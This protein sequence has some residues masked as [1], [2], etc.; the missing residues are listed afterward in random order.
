MIRTI[1]NFAHLGIAVLAN[2]VHAFP[3]RK[4]TVI[5]VTGTDGKTTTTN[6]IYHILNSS[7]KKAAMIS[8]IGAAVGGKMHDIGFHVTTPSSFAVQK[9]IKKAVAVGTEYLVL[10]VTSHG[11]DQNRAYGIE[12]AIS[13]VTN[14]THEH[15]DYHKTYEKYL[16][17]K[18]K[19][20]LASKIAVLNRDDESYKMLSS[21]LRVPHSTY[22]GQESSKFGDRKIITYGIRGEAD[23]TAKRFPFKTK[24]LGEFNKY[25][26]LAAIAVCR[27]L[28]L[29]DEQITKALATFEAPV[30]RQ[31][32]VY[33]KDFTVMVDFAHT[34][35]S[36]RMLLPDLKKVTRGRLI[37]VFGAAA[38]R[39]TSKRPIM[40]EESAKYSDI[41]VL[42]AEDP[43]DEPVEKINEM[44]KAGIKNPKFEIRSSKQIQNSK[45]LSNTKYIIEISDRKKAIE[46][47]ISIAQKGDY[48]VV[49][50][51]SHEKSMNY[52]KGEEAW[53]EFEV[54]NNALKIR[55]SNHETRNNK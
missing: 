36:F 31:E 48:I 35:N 14:V 40:G 29:S 44:I 55:N 15:L 1:K 46:Y 41:I 23:V 9:Y 47:A 4:L 19:L 8:T 42:T 43:R 49:T 20:L 26:C 32:I 38:Q 37:H 11:L 33:D 28:G 51:K 50:G 25:N 27:E 24:L 2:I 45:L 22:S 53:N 21:K 13:V 39:D 10:E 54:V 3:S 34:P 5:G 7:G 16:N 52:G 6:L 30:G 18:A 12:F 17:A